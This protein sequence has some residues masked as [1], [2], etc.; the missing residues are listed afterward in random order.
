[1][2]AIE[3]HLRLDARSA[4]SYSAVGRTF[5]ERD[6]VSG[7]TV[8]GEF[9]DARLRVRWLAARIS[10]RLPIT[11]HPNAARVRVAGPVRRRR[12][13]G[14]RGCA[15]DDASPWRN[16]G[17]GGIDSV[18]SWPVR[19]WRIPSDGACRAR[20]PIYPHRP[21]AA[22]RSPTAVSTG[23]PPHSRLTTV[24]LE[25]S[26]WFA[27][28]HATV[29]KT[30][31]ERSDRRQRRFATDA[32]ATWLSTRCHG[33]ADQ[34]AAAGRDQHARERA[35]FRGDEPERSPSQYAAAS[36]RRAVNHRCGQVNETTL[37][38]RLHHRESMDSGLLR[39]Q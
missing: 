6:D 20:D 17:Q 9:R 8:V 19:R 37:P 30:V 18:T 12:K 7:S 1:M 21:H 34:S 35:V 13:S 4:R 2:I 16:E 32:P 15:D 33:R 38:R 23:A 26:D 10:D 31:R 14:L 5:V 22:N 27:P 36:S 39:G 29:G 3:N 11:R 28:R 25:R 24:C